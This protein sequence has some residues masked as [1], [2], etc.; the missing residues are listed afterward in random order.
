MKLSKSLGFQRNII[1][2]NIQLKSS[3]GSIFNL[4]SSNVK[5]FSMFC[6]HLSDYCMDDFYATDLQCPFCKD[7]SF[8]LNNA[9]QIYKI[10]KKCNE[11]LLLRYEK[12]KKEK[13]HFQ[14]LIT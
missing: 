2:Q 13:E 1:R 5:K 8:R 10:V 9:I 11:M 6:L 4:K 3:F 7:L 12:L 14:R